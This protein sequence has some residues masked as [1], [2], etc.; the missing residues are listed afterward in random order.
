MMELFTAYMVGMAAAMFYLRIA[1][2]D[3]IPA[4][5]M[6]SQGVME[7]FTAYTVGMAEAFTKYK[8]ED[9]RFPA[10]LGVCSQKNCRRDIISKRREV[11][12]LLG[13]L[14][15]LCTITC[16]PCRMRV[17]RLLSLR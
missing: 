5:E 8:G 12:L 10:L 11:Q 15:A 16:S 14:P 2:S 7:L 1:G 3:P 17:V 9:G 4:L 6:P 13:L